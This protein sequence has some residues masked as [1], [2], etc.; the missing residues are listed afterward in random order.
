VLFKKTD[1]KQW[2]E[3]DIALNMKALEFGLAGLIL[4][5]EKEL[6]KCPTRDEVYSEGHA[7]AGTRMYPETGAGQNT[8]NRAEKT[9]DT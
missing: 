5:A 3:F 9:W 2:P 6:L 8:F 1:P 7:T 4:T